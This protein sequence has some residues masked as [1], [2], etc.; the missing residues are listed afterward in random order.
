M[1]DRIKSSVQIIFSYCLLKFV[2]P[3][4]FDH[5]W[6]RS[7]VYWKSCTEKCVYW[8]VRLETNL[9]HL[10]W[11]T[12]LARLEVFLGKKPL[13]HYS[14]FEGS[15]FS[16]RKNQQQFCLL[17]RI[18]ADPSRT[19]TYDLIMCSQKLDFTPLHSHILT[20]ISRMGLFLLPSVST[21]LIS[22]ALIHFFSVQFRICS[23]NWS[24]TG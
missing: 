12:L 16:A 1:Q 18:V 5:F 22:Y 21:H 10:Y 8:M 7:N 11:A 23:I 6:W 9:L 2:A 24:Y 4:H 15:T 3:F 17:E 14:E 19:K 13:K 20:G